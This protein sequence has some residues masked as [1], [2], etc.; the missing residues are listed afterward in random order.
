M[1]HAM[2]LNTRNRTQSVEIILSFHSQLMASPKSRPNAFA[3]VSSHDT[4][5]PF[6]SCSHRARDSDAQPGV[7]HTQ[8]TLQPSSRGSYFG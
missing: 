2:G 4:S 6:L 1:D 7:W 8:A 5:P 3:K